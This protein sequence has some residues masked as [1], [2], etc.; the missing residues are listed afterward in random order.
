MVRHQHK[1]AEHAEYAQEHTAKQNYLAEI[2]QLKQENQKLKEQIKNLKIKLKV[3]K[4]EE[5]DS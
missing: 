3:N 5:H 2:A 4:N 1:E